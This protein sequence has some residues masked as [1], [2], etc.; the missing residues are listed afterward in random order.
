MPDK[1]SIRDI[2]RASGYSPST[3]SKALNGHREIN[4]ETA[5][6]IRDKAAV[7]GY[8]GPSAGT[9]RSRRDHPHPRRLMLVR[10]D[11]EYSPRRFSAALVCELF[12]EQAAR[13]GCQVI[14][15]AQKETDGLLRLREAEADGAFLICEE[16]MLY[17]PDIAGLL[18]SDMPVVTIDRRAEG[19][20]CVSP[21]LRDAVREVLA[22]ICGLGHKRISLIGRDDSREDRIFRALFLREAQ[23]LGI[24]KPEDRL[25]TL[26]DDSEQDLE[27]SIRLMLA[28]AAP[29]TCLLC[30]DDLTACRAIEL[31]EG[32]G[33]SVPEE[34]SVAGFGEL[35]ESSFLKP[36]LTTYGT[37]HRRAAEEALRCLLRD[38]ERPLWRIPETIRIPGHMVA[39]GSIGPCPDPEREAKKCADQGERGRDL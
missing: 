27:R 21:D 25:C 2:A 31:L 22:H 19:C 30:Q 4:S 3:V 16:K 13:R 33:I 10:P 9:V 14:Y 36:R 35:P 37:D 32:A 17:R 20:I 6:V 38:I 29:P 7:L 1:P 39:G 26:P 12:C 18:M 24:E 8:G 5:S 23:N 34:I 15:P 28:G 11:R